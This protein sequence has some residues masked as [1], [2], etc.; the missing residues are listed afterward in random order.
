[1]EKNIPISSPDFKGVTEERDFEA[2]SSI[3]R[4]KG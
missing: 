2:D 4:R 1:M 3:S